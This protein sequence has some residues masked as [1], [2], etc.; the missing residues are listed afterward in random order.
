[1]NSL[2]S[3]YGI[4]YNSIQSVFFKCKCS[5]WIKDGSH[6]MTGCVWQKCFQSH[7][8]DGA[9]KETLA[10]LF[11]QPQ[12]VSTLCLTVRAIESIPTNRSNRSIVSTFFWSST[13]TIHRNNGLLRNM[14][15]FFVCFN[16][17]VKSKVICYY[18]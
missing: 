3:I 17:L 2:P 15:G 10:E 4:V 11:P 5:F 12:P 14:R 13:V 18:F 9:I 8:N 1:M 7:R 16:S 6:H